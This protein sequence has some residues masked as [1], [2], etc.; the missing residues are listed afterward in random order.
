MASKVH[1]MNNINLKNNQVSYLYKQAKFIRVICIACFTEL[2][3]ISL[4]RKCN[5]SVLLFP[6]Y[7]G[8]V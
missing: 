7:V 8:V 1:G 2:L 6:P 3:F 5:I 4:Y